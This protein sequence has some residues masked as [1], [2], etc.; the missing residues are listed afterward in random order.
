MLKKY[1]WV[2]C[3]FLVREYVGVTAVS[4]RSMSPT[5]N[6]QTDLENDVCFVL[7]TTKCSKGDIILFKHPF[8]NIPTVKRVGGVED[9]MKQFRSKFIKVPKGH[10]FVEA[11][12]SFHGQDSRDFGPI[13]LGLVQGKILGVI[14]PLKRFKLF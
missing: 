6:P 5:I 11:E 2:P 9:D 13:P 4:G 8:L 3:L 1:W 10:V 12:E 7:K 14:W